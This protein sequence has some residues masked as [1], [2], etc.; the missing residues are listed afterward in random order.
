VR[1]VLPILAVVLLLTGC[2]P[3]TMVAAGVGGSAFVNHAL[4]GISYRTFSA[5]AKNVKTAS[6]GALH[7]MGLRVV[8]SERNRNGSETLKAKGIDRE[9]EITL[10]RIS[11]NTTRMKVLARDGSVFFDGAT[12][13]E[14]L[15]QTEKRLTRV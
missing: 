6:I 11:P 14:I 1:R 13:Q 8:G 10:E 5:P 9:I 2:E 4:N 12:A 15:L 3:F 7:R